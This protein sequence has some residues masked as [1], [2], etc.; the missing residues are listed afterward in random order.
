MNRASVSSTVVT[1]LP[2]Q[3]ADMLISSTRRPRPSSSIRAL[4]M[5]APSRGG[6]DVG[7]CTSRRHA[8]THGRHRRYLCGRAG[9]CPARVDP[10]RARNRRLRA[11]EQSRWV[12]AFTIRRAAATGL[13]AG[14]IRAVSSSPINL[15]N[16]GSRCCF[17]LFYRMHA[18]FAQTMPSF[19]GIYRGAAC[20]LVVR[21]G[22]PRYKAPRTACSVTAWLLSRH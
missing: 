10:R 13:A 8:P 14:C 9:I 19:A 18:I 16:Y 1:T 20:T 7:P 17:A 2:M 22:D 3:T 21:L 4:L 11:P 15:L 6:N 5:R 12:A